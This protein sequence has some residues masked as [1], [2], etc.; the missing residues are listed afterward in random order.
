MSWLDRPISSKSSSFLSCIGLGF[1]AWILGHRV[2]M[3]VFESIAFA[4]TVAAS[5][6]GLVDAAKSNAE[7]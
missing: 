4:V 2:G 6:G 5:V 7:S 3:E 1:A